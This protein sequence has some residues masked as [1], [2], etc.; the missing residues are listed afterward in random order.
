MRLVF[1]EWLDSIGCASNWS[2]LD[3]SRADPL[4]CRS[5][6]WLLHDTDACKVVV[7][8]ITNIADDGVTPQGCGDMTIPTCAVTRMVDLTDPS[9]ITVAR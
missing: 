9:D 1:I 2:S 4:I 6:G 3:G 8:H 7:P 5:V